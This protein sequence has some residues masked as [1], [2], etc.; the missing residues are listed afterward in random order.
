MLRIVRVLKTLTSLFFI[1][2]LLLTYSFT[3]QKVNVYIDLEK[4]NLIKAE[5]FFFFALGAFIFFNLIFLIFDKT[6]VN[7][8]NKK[9]K[10][11]NLLLT[12]KFQSW[13]HGLNAAINIFLTSIVLFIGFL[14]SDNDYK[15]LDYTFLLYIGPVAILIALFSLP[16]VFIPRHRETS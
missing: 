11:S 7:Y 9:K 5:H 6:L 10:L 12:D 4:L 1:A 8:R 16:F 15:L 14:N 13:V 3:V 2:A